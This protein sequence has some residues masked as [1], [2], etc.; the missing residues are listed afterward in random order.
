MHFADVARPMDVDFIYSVATDAFKKENGLPAR[1]GELERAPADGILIGEGLN[2]G[3]PYATVWRV[4]SGDA[5]CIKT[6]E[7]NANKNF[8]TVRDTDEHRAKR[9]FAHWMERHIGDAAATLEWTAN[10]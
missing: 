2:A 9:Y 8:F 3:V 10:T 7:P 4:A 6:V 1:A 5:I